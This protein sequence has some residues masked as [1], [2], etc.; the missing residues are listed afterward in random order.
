MPSTYNGNFQISGV[1]GGGES[2]GSNIG[3]LTTEYAGTQVDANVMASF[4]NK[5]K[6]SIDENSRLTNL[7]YNAQT[8]GSFI[9]ITWGTARVEGA[10]VWASPFRETLAVTSWKRLSA[11]GRPKFQTNLGYNYTVDVGYSFGYNG[12]NRR[13][14]LSRLYMNNT[15]VYDFAGSYRYPGMTFRFKDGS[16]D[17]MPDIAYIRDK[18]EDAIAFR[19]QLTVFVD[20]LPIADFGAAIPTVWAEIV[21]EDEI[22]YT[23]DPF[24]PYISSDANP[25]NYNLMIDWV[26]RRVYQPI[27]NIKRDSGDLRGGLAIY[28]LDSKLQIAEVELTGNYAEI[29][30]GF[31]I[32]AA[33]YCPWM[34]LIFCSVFNGQKMFVIEADTGRVISRLTEFDG[35][36]PFPS[37]PYRFAFCP[38]PENADGCYLAFT[39]RPFY[40]SI[41]LGR[42]DRNGQL[43]GTDFV[44]ISSDEVN[45]NAYQVSGDDTLPMLY[46]GWT[47]SD[48]KPRVGR[49][50]CEHLT[51][52]TDWLEFPAE[53]QDAGYV[54]GILQWNGI[55][56]V[57]LLQDVDDRSWI[58]G[59]DGETKEVLY[60]IEDTQTATGTMDSAFLLNSN[61]ESGVIGYKFS[62]SGTHLRFL[63]IA[64][65]SLEKEANV[66][67]LDGFDTESA[68]D[69]DSRS[70]YALSANRPIKINGKPPAAQMMR[71]DEWMAD[72]LRIAGYDDS[73]FAIVNVD[74]EIEGA[75]ISKGYDAIKMLDDVA[76]L[77]RITRTESDGKLR[78]QKKIEDEGSVEPEL[79]IDYA[80]LAW[81]NQSADSRH[82]IQMNMVDETNTPMEATVQFINPD[83]NYQDDSF[84]Y[85]RPGVVSASAQSMGLAVP[86]MMSKERV[87]VLTQNMLYDTWGS[88]LTGSVRLPRRYY[89]IDEGTI[90][91]LT[92]NTFSDIVRLTEVTHNGDYSVSAVFEVVRAKRKARGN[93]DAYV[94]RQSKRKGRPESELYFFDVPLLS[95]DDAVAGKIVIYM[96]MAG[97]GQPNWPGGYLANATESGVFSA[98]GNV[99]NDTPIGRSINVA[100]IAA[101]SSDD[102]RVMFNGFNPCEGLNATTAELASNPGRNLAFYG[103]NGRWE[104]VQWKTATLSDKGYVIFDGVRRGLRGTRTFDHA[105]GDIFVP[106][107]PNIRKV[108][109]PSSIIGTTQLFKA[110]GYGLPLSRVPTYEFVIA[111]AAL[112]PWSPV[113]K[114]TATRASGG[115]IELQ[116][117]RRDRLGFNTLGSAA[118]LPQSD[119]PEAY[120][121]ELL[122][123]LGGVAR[124]V[125]GL[126][127]P[128]W[129]Y[130]AAMQAADGLVGTPDS[131]RVRVYQMSHAAGIGRGVAGEDTVYVV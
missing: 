109:F 8:W 76:A 101:G 62:R 24:D 48:D 66:T 2:S 1:V 18:G 123:G 16:P 118:E 55:I 45:S 25:S 72:V 12:S 129:T 78:Y 36:N 46:F 20:N 59:F 111:A 49:V 63:D 19:N 7:K 116:W 75:F 115:D 32:E 33:A 68:W 98:I 124:A 80:N 86:L 99:S 117:Y 104:I 57:W 114:R 22:D 38:D 27:N 3:T 50:D 43:V 5:I 82:A 52:E 40:T 69:G 112:K 95:P 130:T 56:V 53:V 21:S 126:S 91:N 61:V 65:G 60:T 79:T 41:H 120:E 90:V 23:A 102:L 35:D 84:T 17:Q 11:S 15:I 77:H 125:S 85:K 83:I 131:L 73:E 92:H 100:P 39:D 81:L 74:D 110:V 113:V 97:V 28:D 14:F 70:F 96:T 42:F 9:P 58:I 4:G 13:R 26:R 94:A 107:T 127:A 34:Q 108:A 67:I 64:S 88:Q 37:F 47:D 128:S 30:D 89:A 44:T 105:T 6:W 93:V 31:V 122:D 119:P 10:I 51:Y 87:A 121:L 54:N 106:L 29:E 71:L 103:V